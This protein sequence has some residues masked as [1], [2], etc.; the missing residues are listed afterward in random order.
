[1]EK[2]A[3]LLVCVSVFQEYN[4]GLKGR[5]ESNAE[6]ESNNSE[7]SRTREHKKIVYNSEF[8]VLGFA[9]F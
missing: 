2:E 6:A 8:Y 4:R 3:C 5:E 1:M 7:N 9:S